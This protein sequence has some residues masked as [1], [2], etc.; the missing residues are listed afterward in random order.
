MNYYIQ[1]NHSELTFNNENEMN[2]IIQKLEKKLKNIEKHEN[3]EFNQKNNQIIRYLIKKWKENAIY[4]D[5]NN[6]TGKISTTLNN[7]D[8]TELF[9]SLL[10]LL[11]E[12][13]N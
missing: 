10:Y 11:I 6:P 1:G 8:V 2:C 7:E 3:N 13:N 9:K 4:D 12:N 5:E